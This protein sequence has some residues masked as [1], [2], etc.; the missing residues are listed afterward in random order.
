MSEIPANRVTWF[1]L[2]ADDVQRA[3]RFYGDVFG[4]RQEDAYAN[5]VRAG[6]INGE[7]AARD[8]ALQEPRLVVRVD[9]IDKTIERITA[10]GGR[11]SV[12]R[13]EIPE[14]G[15]VYAS[16]IDTEQNTVNIVGDL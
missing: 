4:W 3:W 9:D 1:Q 13:T 14:I 5:E 10:A 7:I 12:G 15:M 8:E 2:P 11:L 6:A 16:F